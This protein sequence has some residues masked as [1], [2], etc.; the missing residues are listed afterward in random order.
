VKPSNGFGITS[1]LVTAPAVLLQTMMTNCAQMPFGTVRQTIQ[2]TAN[3]SP[4][5]QVEFMTSMAVV[6]Q[7]DRHATP[8]GAVGGPYAIPVPDLQHSPRAFHDDMGQLVRQGRAQA[9]RMIHELLVDDNAAGHRP[10]RGSTEVPDDESACRQL[11]CGAKPMASGDLVQQTFCHRQ[12]LAID[13]HRLR[14][15]RVSRLL[16]QTGPGVGRGLFPVCHGQSGFCMVGC[17]VP[18]G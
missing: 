13:C 15:K 7:G 11:H 17:I 1:P 5:L 9:A 18:G 10:S 3:S 16:V 2:I 14:A 4:R 6:T 8:V 12:Q